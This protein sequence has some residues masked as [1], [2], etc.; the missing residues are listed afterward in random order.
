MAPSLN[1]I[2]DIAEALQTCQVGIAEDSC[3]A[4]RNRNASCRRCADV[5][6]VRAVTVRANQISIDSAACTNCGACAV[7]CPTRALAVLQPAYADVVGSLADAVAACAGQGVDEPMAVIACARRASKREADASCFAVVPC[8]AYIDEELLVQV[9]A[10]GVGRIELVDGVC[11]TCKYRDTGAAIDETVDQAR[12]LVSAF[13]GTTRIERVSAFPEGMPGPD[14]PAAFG[15]SRR[16]FFSDAAASAKDSVASAVAATM[17]RQLGTEAEKAPIGERLRV[18]GQGLMAKIPVPYHEAL[19]D[20]LDRIGDPA[21]ETI[22][23]RAFASIDIDTEQCNNCG[24]CAVFCPTT[25]LRRNPGE[26]SSRVEYL[27]FQACD[28]I[29]CGLCADVCFKGCLSVQG[30]VRLDEL[31][32]FEPRTFVLPEENP[33]GNVFGSFGF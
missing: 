14:S 6:P 30:E 2:A 12:N 16:A 25:A 10:C 32:D 11:R 15:Q 27:E 8:L 20:A 1:D 26:A 19:L 33:S 23:A 18:D 29:A 7:V 5:C 4:V 22:A 28:C 21:V 3:L 31:L 17:R 24:M 13:G 9:A